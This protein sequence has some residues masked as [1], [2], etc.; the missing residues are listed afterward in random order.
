VQQKT[1]NCV[2]ELKIDSEITVD[3]EVGMLTVHVTG[4]IQ[5]LRF[6]SAKGKMILSG[7]G[8]LTYEK[9]ELKA[10]DKDCIF[11]VPSDGKFVYVMI[12]LEPVFYPRTPTSA[13]GALQDFKLSIISADTPVIE[14]K[15]KCPDGKAKLP[16]PPG[17]LWHGLYTSAHIDDIKEGI[18]KWDILYE[19]STEPETDDFNHPIYARK[20]SKP[21]DISPVFGTWVDKSTFVLIN[22]TTK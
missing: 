20:V 7:E 10:V 22:N 6:T 15:I 17:S 16:L 21:E 5:D 2:L 18:S 13:G 4:T 8:N 11:N 9:I 3:F 19:K 14:I 1:K 12:T